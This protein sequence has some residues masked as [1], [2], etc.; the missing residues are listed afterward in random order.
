M[1]PAQT[2]EEK[3]LGR[4]DRVVALLEDLFILE[5]APNWHEQGTPKADT[6]N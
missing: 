4:L 5:A 1:K 2:N 3:I 6:E